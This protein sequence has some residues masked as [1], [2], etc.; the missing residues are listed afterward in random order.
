M[1]HH[2]LSR[3]R[4]SRRALLQVAAAG[5]AATALPRAAAARRA[6][7]PS[8]PKPSYVNTNGIRMAVYEAGAGVPVVFSHGFPELAYSW[9]HQLPALAGAGFHAIAPDQRGYGNTQRPV[10]I[11]AYGI[12]DL[13]DDLVGMLDA[14]GIDKAVFCGHDW[15]G[16][17]VWNMA[18]L[19]PKRVL[20]VIGVNTAFGPPA[21][22]PPIELLRRMRGDDNYVVAFQTPGVAE[23]VLEADVRKVFV[24]LLRRG[25]W[26]AEEFAKLPPDDPQRKFQ[27]LELLK[28]P[29]DEALLPGEPLLNEEELQVFVSTFERTGFAGGINWYRNIDRNW[30][31]MRNLDYHIEQPCLYVGAEDDIVLPPSSA[32]GLERIAPKVEKVTIPDCGHWTQQ[33]KPAELNRILIDWLR[34]TFA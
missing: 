10:E 31:A 9:R 18:L 21:P 15:G 16:G 23:A 24:M 25:M 14:K 27:L 26:D 33:E 19:H 7:A 5:A 30:R 32:N 17:V 29:V 13:C 8:F 2:D 1:L 34:K 28:A 22:G 3:A 20:G 4:L 11:E 12:R 6:E